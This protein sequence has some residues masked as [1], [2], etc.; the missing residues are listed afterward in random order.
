MR[1]VQ[2]NIVNCFVDRFADDA[3]EINRGL[4]ER[5]ILA[6]AKRSKIRFVTHYHLDE[7]AVDAAADAF[8]EILPLRRARRAHA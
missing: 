8:A 4:R 3:A 7:A 1:R 6:N 5:G 2:T